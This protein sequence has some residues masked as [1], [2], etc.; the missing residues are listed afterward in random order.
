MKIIYRKANENDLMTYFHWANEEDT[1]N[2]SFNSEKIDIQSH[3]LWY[4]YKIASTECQLLLFENSNGNAVGQVRIERSGED[5]IISISID[6]M[7]RGK[8]LS[9]FMID[10]A[11]EEYFRKFAKSTIVAYIKASN[12][13]SQKAFEKAGFKLFKMSIVHGEDKLILKKE[14]V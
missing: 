10:S 14:N 11:C 3:T 4:L 12:I 13:V 5:S 6:K 8:A 7:F 1:R 9:C 2:N